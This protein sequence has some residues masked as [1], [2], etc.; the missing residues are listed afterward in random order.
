MSYE[1]IRIN[2]NT[3]RIEDSGVRFFLLSGT[4]KALLIDSGMQVNNANAEKAAIRIRGKYSGQR[5]YVM[6]TRCISGGLGTLV[7]NMVALKEAGAG[8][9]EVMDPF[10]W[11]MNPRW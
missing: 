6:D 2:D 5:L 4:E 3:W 10:L 7:E 8:Y 9:D 11:M 1:V